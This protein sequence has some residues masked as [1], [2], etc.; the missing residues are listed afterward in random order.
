MRTSISFTDE[1]VTNILNQIIIDKNNKEDLVHILS[2]MLCS[3]SSAVER[4]VHC[5]LGKKLPEIIPDGTIV[6]I[7]INQ[8]S[9][10]ADKEQTKEKFGDSNDRIIGTILSFRGFFEYSNYTI[11]CKCIDKNGKEVVLTSYVS[12]D[13]VE[14]V[15]EF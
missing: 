1:D 2:S 8:I 5:Y 13:N 11:N 15:D 14:V 12:L 7:P 9:Y 6:T 4:F 3:N 10:D